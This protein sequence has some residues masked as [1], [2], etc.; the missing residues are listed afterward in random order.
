MN[1]EEKVL[2][3][4]NENNEKNVEITI[5]TDLKEEAGFDSFGYLMILNALEDE[6]SIHIDET[7]FKN[8]R[9]VSHIAGALR[10]HYPALEREN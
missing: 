3:I 1:I 6:Y 9:T 8:L 4:V 7:Q 10:A 2:D 5:D